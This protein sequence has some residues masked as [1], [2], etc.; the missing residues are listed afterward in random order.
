MQR[1]L[2]HW[3]TILEGIVAQPECLITDL[4]LLT[5]A[6]RVQ[7]LSAWNATETATASEEVSVHRLIERQVERTP[8]TIALRCGTEHLTYQQLNLQANR[9]AHVLQEKRISPETPVIFFAERD[10][11]FAIAMLAIFKAG[12]IY[13]PVDP[14]HPEER[15]RRVLQESHAVLALTTRTYLPALQRLQ[16]SDAHSLLILSIEDL[17]EQETRDTNP[18]RPFHVDQVA[19]ILYTSGSTGQPKGV[20]VE[21]RGLLNHLQAKIADVQLSAADNLAQN[22][23][24]SF[25]ISIW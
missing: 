6:E 22:G 9:I 3:Q 13:I 12:G 15:N 5:A 14:F 11:Y 25:D 20:M 8:E 1:L 18:E 23:P 17:L 7:I 19:Y 24:L 16:Q 2:G 4:P 21:H 10:M